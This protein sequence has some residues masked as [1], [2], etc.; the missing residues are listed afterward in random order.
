[1]AACVSETLSSL[2]IASCKPVGPFGCCRPALLLRN[3]ARCIVAARRI[4]GRRIVAAR[5]IVGRRIVAARRIV[6]RGFGPRV[7]CGRGRLPFGGDVFGRCGAVGAAA[8]RDGR[9]LRIRA[10][11]IRI[12]LP[13]DHRRGEYGARRCNHEGNACDAQHGEQACDAPASCC[14]CARNAGQHRVGKCGRRDRRCIMQGRC[15][16]RGRGAGRCRGGF[17]RGFRRR[18]AEA[19]EEST[20]QR[21]GRHE[22]VDAA[23]GRRADGAQVAHLTLQGRIGRQCGKETLLVG[24]VKLSV[25]IALHQGIKIA[26]GVRIHFGCTGLSS[27]SAR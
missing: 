14:G 25:E 17:C 3:A 10:C 2:E 21:H 8:C 13:E 23:D 9:I 15:G 18:D 22:A 26:V 6:G 16:V 4:V 5:R 24:T 27:N 12:V 20:R 1:M 11:R 7:G 19:C